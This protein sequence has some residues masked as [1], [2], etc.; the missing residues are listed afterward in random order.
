MAKKR[1]AKRKGGGSSMLNPSERKTYAEGSIAAKDASIDD[2]IDFTNTP[3]VS[4]DYPTKSKIHPKL[5]QMILQK[6]EGKQMVYSFLYTLNI[7]TV[8]TIRD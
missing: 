4:E 2:D 7:L 8:L 6:L 5:E 3:F 1:R